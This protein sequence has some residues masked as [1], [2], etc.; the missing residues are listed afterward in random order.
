MKQ[1]HGSFAKT[2]CARIQDDHFATC[3]PKAYFD[4]DKIVEKIR[5]MQKEF[6][7]SLFHLHL[8]IGVYEITNREEPVSK[9]CDKANLASETIKMITRPVLLIMTD[10]CWNSPLPSERSSVS[11]KKHWKRKNLSC[12]CN[13]RLTNRERCWGRKLWYAGNIRNGGFWDRMLSLMCWKRPV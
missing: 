8:Y 10:I 11:L 3:I 6:T 4:E 2:V 12:F 5:N 13:R 1:L 7:N 9:M